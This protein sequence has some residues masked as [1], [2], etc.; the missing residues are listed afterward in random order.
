MLQPKVVKLLTT[1]K[2]H[3]AHGTPTVYHI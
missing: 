2:F 1:E 3:G